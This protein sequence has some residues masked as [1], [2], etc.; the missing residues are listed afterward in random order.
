MARVRRALP[1]LL[2]LF[3]LPGRAVEITSF[4]P[5]AVTLGTDVAIFG[6]FTDLLV[7]GDVV[8]PRVVGTRPDTKQ[9]VVFDLLS[10]Q[11]SRLDVRARKFPSSKLDPAGGKTWNL[12]VIPRKDIGPPVQATDL[13]TS[14][15]PVL[16]DVGF[17]MGLPGDALDLLIDAAGTG[18]LSVLFGTRKAK[19]AQALLVTRALGP[20]GAESVV[21]T[22]IVPKL[23]P[24]TYPISVN[25]KVGPS[26][27]VDFTVPTPP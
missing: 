27:T 24:G 3:A 11:P 14:V 19:P 15:A 16:T 4:S 10:W 1:C 7:G 20:A 18:K 23:P 9:T 2:L 21:L 22:V 8:W 25:N 17:N 6:T 12:V 13:F 5:S 26:N